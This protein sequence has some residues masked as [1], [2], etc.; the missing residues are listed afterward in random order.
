V[1]WTFVGILSF[2]LVIAILYTVFAYIQIQVLVTAVQN[3]IRGTEG[4]KRSVKD[5]T[6][7]P[8]TR[9]SSDIVKDPHNKDVTFANKIA[10]R[11]NDV[12]NDMFHKDNFEKQYPWEINVNELKFNKKIGAGSFGEVYFGSWLGTD[13]AIKMLLNDLPAEQE[14]NFRAEIELVRYEG[15]RIF[16][17]WSCNAYS[18]LCNF[19][20]G[21]MSC[22]LVSR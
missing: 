21:Y 8:L 1:V 5:I 15:Q 19:K 18:F 12:V 2:I 9:E 22:V 10:H 4:R 7:S 14:E 13:V 20:L 11:V 3:S 16:C 6:S 17:K